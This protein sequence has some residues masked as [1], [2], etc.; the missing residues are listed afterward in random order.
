MLMASNGGLEEE[1]QSSL[2]VLILKNLLCSL[3]WDFLCF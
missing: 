1:D 3:Q 2:L